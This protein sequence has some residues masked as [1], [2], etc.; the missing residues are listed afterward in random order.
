MCEY[1]NGNICQVT[2]TVC[3]YM[4]YCSKIKGYKP[5]RSMPNNCPQKIKAKIP[6]GYNRVIQERKGK[7][8]I[9]VEGQAV[10]VS[11]P[12]DYTPS[13]VKV[14]KLKNGVIKLKTEFNERGKT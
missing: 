11:N 8:Y 3:P 10:I 12:F 4:S 9:D 2:N 14:I 1:V 6:V 7:L 5:L 13:Y